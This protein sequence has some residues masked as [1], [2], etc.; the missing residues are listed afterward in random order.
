M[1]GCCLLTCNCYGVKWHFYSCAC[2][3]VS[4]GFQQDETCGIMCWRLL[5]NMPSRLI[6]MGLHQKQRLQYSG[7]ASEKAFAGRTQDK[8]IDMAAG[9][10]IIRGESAHSMIAAL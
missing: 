10:A 9:Y 3:L 8:D 1:H 5:P 4:N 6:F 7:S 2:M